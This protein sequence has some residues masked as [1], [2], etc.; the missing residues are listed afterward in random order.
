MFFS[1]RQ[2][3]DETGTTLPVLSVACYHIATMKP[4]DGSAEIQSDART[5]QVHISRILSLIEAFKQVFGII[6]LSQSLAAINHIQEHLLI[7]LLNAED[8]FAA[9][10]RIFKGIRQQ[11]GYRLI[12]LVAVY[13]CIHRRLWHLQ[14]DMNTTQVGIIGEER[15]QTLRKLHQVGFPAREVHLMLVQASLVENLI[16]Q[17]E[18]SLCVSVDGINIR[19]IFLSISQSLLQFLQR[20]HNQRQRRT[21]IVGGIDEELH[22]CLFQISLL[23]AQ[24]NNDNG[25][26]EAENQEEIDELRPNGKKPRCQH[27]QI[28]HLIIHRILAVAIGTHFYT[29][30]SIRQTCEVEVIVSSRIA[31][32]FAP[33]DAIL[34]HDVTH[35]LIIKQGEAE[36]YRLEIRRNTQIISDK[37][38][39]L[40]IKQHTRQINGGRFL[41]IIL[42]LRRPKISQS[43]GVS[44]TD[45]P[46]R[47]RTYYSRQ[48]F[49]GQESVSLFKREK[50]LS[51][52]IITP[53]TLRSTHP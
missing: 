36:H 16:H 2:F 38:S 7:L 20:L 19:L 31:D 53:D 44:I 9:I 28:D 12:Q 34:E 46:I 29:I 14:P 4:Y 8:D 37:R 47:C 41:I 49:L 24:K 27:I 6:V 50:R 22:L 18:Q 15:N 3:Y 48:I 32:P 5:S 45:N 35:A 1:Q 39:H 23:L 13:P 33:I 52:T 11:I 43:F 40:S 10:R 25:S 30:M 42:Y 26:R 17:G 51:F 21:D